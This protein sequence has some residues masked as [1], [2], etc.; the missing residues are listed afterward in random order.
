MALGLS[1]STPYFQTYK[2]EHGDYS[3]IRG[4]YQSL[5]PFQLHDDTARGLGMFA[6]LSLPA[7]DERRYFAPSAC[8]AARL[9]VQLTTQFWKN[10]TVMAILGYNQG[11]GNAVKFANRWTFN[12]PET[13]TFRTQIS[14][15]LLDYVNDKL[16]IYFIANNRHKF[17]FD[18]NRG[19]TTSLPQNAAPTKFRDSQCQTWWNQSQPGS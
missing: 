19:E 8:G 9:M 10:D 1:E 6:Q 16:A 14:K 12:W 13:E 15:T 7:N 2:I 18:S 3:K 5:G 11:G 17:G 4:G